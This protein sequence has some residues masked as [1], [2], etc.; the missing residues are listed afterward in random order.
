MEDIEK[1][2]SGLCNVLEEVTFKLYPELELI[3]EHLISHGALGSLMSGSG[4]TIFGIFE[5]VRQAK[6]A[7]ERI[8]LPGNKIY[9][10]QMG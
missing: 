9:V 5:N 4:P 2:A 10:S 6:I 7:A 1:I 8:N 3:K